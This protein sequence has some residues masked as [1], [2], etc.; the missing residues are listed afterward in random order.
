[1]RS[2]KEVPQT[3]R[4]L[5]VTDETDDPGLFL[6]PS[7]LSGSSMGKDSARVSNYRVFVKRHGETEGVFP[8][9]GDKGSF[10][11]AIRI[12]AITP[13]I[14]D[15][16]IALDGHPALEDDDMEAVGHD[17]IDAAWDDWARYEFVRA[18][19]E[20]FPDD[21]DAIDALDADQIRSLF[22]RVRIRLGL[23]WIEDS[24]SM[25]I[26]VAAVAADVSLKDLTA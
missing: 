24:A 16:L 12:S 17:A 7:S 22:D 11:V 2:E 10:A 21:A 6:V 20:S 15:D 3:L 14:L 1:M 5:R 18:L 9:I 23:E 19:E 26:D 25:F 8:V 13:N 4:D